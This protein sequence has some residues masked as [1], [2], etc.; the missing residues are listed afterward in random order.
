[1]GVDDDHGDDDGSNDEDHGEEHVFADERDGAGRGRDQ[2][3]DNQQEHGERKQDRDAEG[4]LL[5]CT[6]T[7]SCWMAHLS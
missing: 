3:H 5:T 2:F 1:M 6:E 4:H 7:S